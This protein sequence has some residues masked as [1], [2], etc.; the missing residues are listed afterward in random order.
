M[1]P[2][3]FR[4]PKR[5]AGGYF[6]CFFW[7]KSYVSSRVKISTIFWNKTPKKVDP[8]KT[9]FL[10]KH[11]FSPGKTTIFKVR[12]LYEKSAL[13]LQFAIF[14]SKKCKEK[15]SKNAFSWSEKRSKTSLA[16]KIH[17]NGS[18]GVPGGHLF[19]HTTVFG[20]F[21][22]PGWAWLG[23]KMGSGTRPGRFKFF[24]DLRRLKNRHNRLPEASRKVPGHPKGPSRGTILGQ[25]SVNFQGNFWNNKFH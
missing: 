4:D 17:E 5:V 23:P 15:S 21:L 24:I 8:C 12:R 13:E 19:G 2:G 3:Q 18:G 22:G 16:A 25:F 10:E 1:N 9:R 14:V 20:R 6:L 7:E 11:G